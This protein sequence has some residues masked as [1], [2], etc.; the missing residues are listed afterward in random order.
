MYIIKPG[1]FEEIY[2]AKEFV[3]KYCGCEFVAHRGDYHVEDIYNKTTYCVEC[4]CCGDEVHLDGGY[5]N[6]GV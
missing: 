5:A 3:C 4:P 6:R 1:N 2:S